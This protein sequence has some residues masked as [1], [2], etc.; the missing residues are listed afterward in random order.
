MEQEVAK[1]SCG[2]LGAL[3]G[4]TRWPLGGGRR[5]I[6][7]EFELLG[8]SDFGSPTMNREG[9]PS[10]LLATSDFGHRT[11]SMNPDQEL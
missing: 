5:P 2:Q 11:S 9:T 1:F 7:C 8:I 10:S 6:N 4:A 3:P